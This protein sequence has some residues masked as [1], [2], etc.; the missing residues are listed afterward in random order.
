LI[1]TPA[2]LAISTGILVVVGLVSGLYPAIH[3]S[4]L[5]PAEALRYE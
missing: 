1:I 4:R 2:A 3:A 5:D